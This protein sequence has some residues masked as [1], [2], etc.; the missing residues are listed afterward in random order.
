MQ[1]DGSISWKKL[2]PKKVPLKKLSLTV[3]HQ[4]YIYVNAMDQDAALTNEAHIK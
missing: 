4:V 3:A 1:S 2:S